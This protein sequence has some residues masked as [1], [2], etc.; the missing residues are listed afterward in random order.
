MVLTPC[1]FLQRDSAVTKR[2]C[3]P[4]HLRP[5]PRRRFHRK[6]IL[7]HKLEPTFRMKK[8]IVLALLCLLL[9]IAR[10]VVELRSIVRHNW[11]DGSLTPWQ[12]RENSIHHQRLKMAGDAQENGR[13]VFYF[14]LW[15]QSLPDRLVLSQIIFEYINMHAIKHLNHFSSCRCTQFWLQQKVLHFVDCEPPLQVVKVKFLSLLSS[16]KAQ[17]IRSHERC[18]QLN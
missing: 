2:C 5:N 12:K 10:Q 13:S 6:I 1:G 16:R 11:K 3:L 15:C 17:L 9:G 8:I 7:R 14:I 4:I 18:E